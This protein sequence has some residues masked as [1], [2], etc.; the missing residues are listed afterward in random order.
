VTSTIVFESGGIREYVGGY[1]DWLR[2]RKPTQA[3]SAS[4][5]SRST[6]TR[7]ASDGPSPSKRR[8]SFKERQELDSLPA[9][10]EQCE[11]EIG[12]LHHEMAQPGFYQQ[13]G[14]RIAEENARLKS[15]E[16]RLA[17]AYERWASLDAL[18]K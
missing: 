2:Q 12:A 11:V 17:A 10:I 16:E 14:G 7:S 8:L 18:E 15:L 13:P 3:R 1:D 9:A 6:P 4:E 5:S